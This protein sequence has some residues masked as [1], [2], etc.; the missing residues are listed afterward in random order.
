[1][2]CVLKDGEDFIGEVA[3]WCEVQA[4]T[5]VTSTLT[6]NLIKM[7]TLMTMEIHYCSHYIQLFGF[8]L[9]TNPSIPI[10]FNG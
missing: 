3:G 6:V 1:M 8:L 2:P 5:C 10:I 7:V 4:E 9:H